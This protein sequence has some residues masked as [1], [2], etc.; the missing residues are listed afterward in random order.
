MRAATVVALSLVALL[1][2]MAYAHGGTQVNVKGDVRAN[3]AIEIAGEDFAANDVVRIELHR[4]GVE[5][6]ELGRIP[7]DQDG[8]FDETL[9][10]PASVP[11]GIYEL[12]ADGEESATTQVTILEPAAGEPAGAPQ[13]EVAT[14]AVEN[15]RPTGETIGLAAF[16]AVIALGA[17]ALLWTSRTKARAAGA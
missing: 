5:P 3:G 2:G 12:A 10:V 1:P 14:G 15:H 7:A 6:A 8:N 11:A 16:V 13:P 9:H 4:E 17:A